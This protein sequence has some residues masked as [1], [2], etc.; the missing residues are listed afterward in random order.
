[1]A[2]YRIVNCGRD[3]WCVPRGYTPCN[4][5]LSKAPP[6]RSTLFRLQVYERERI[7]LVEVY[8]RV[9]KS[10]FQS[11]DHQYKYLGIGKPL[12]V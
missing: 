6:E 5:L 1:M 7:L 9:G 4:D 11:R 2:V 12:R 3:C 8:Q 10:V